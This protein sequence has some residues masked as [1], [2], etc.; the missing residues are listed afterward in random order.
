MIK[1]VR[2][3]TQLEL[4]RK[5]A[6]DGKGLWAIASALKVIGEGAETSAA[7]PSGGDEDAPAQ[8]P[9][10]VRAR[11]DDVREL[12]ETAERM[13]ENLRA[14]QA[15]MAQSNAPPEDQI[16]RAF[17]AEP[18]AAELLGQ[19]KAAVARRDNARRMTRNAGDPS[20]LQAQRRVRAIQDE[21]SELYRVRR[22][23]VIASLGRSEGS[24]TEAAVRKAEA[25]L[26]VLRA[27]EKVLSERLARFGGEAAGA[28]DSPA[29]SGGA[30][31]GEKA[32]SARRG[33]AGALLDSIEQSVKAIEAMRGEIRHKF[34]EDLMASKDSEVDRLTEANLRSNL[35][36]A[37][38]MFNSV[39]EQL[40][41]AQLVSD[42]STIH[43]E[44][45]HEPDVNAVRP[46]LVLVLALALIAGCT[47]GTL[48]AF[49]ADTLDARIRTLPEIRRALDLSVLGLVPHIPHEAEAV[50]DHVGL[51]CLSAPRSMIAESYKSI[52]T[53]LEF[54]R[55]NRR[56]QVLLITSFTTS[57]ASG[58]WSTC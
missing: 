55:R 10:Q 57:A 12:R 26:V 51:I 17:Q 15:E 27:Q 19:L 35:D 4:G 28:P 41:Q 20:L 24:E 8:T 56:L 50:E 52:R 7:P 49:L 40:K 25:E 45:L 13:V 38:A 3:K 53:S 44:T 42:Y 14:E 34:D 58:G 29:G 1:E 32:A 54:H 30:S 43:A 6:A 31:G 46:H 33:Q 2:L 5:L 21:L 37:R 11:L 36:R 23:V 47:L 16:V 18:D 22:T 9:G 39:V 48:G